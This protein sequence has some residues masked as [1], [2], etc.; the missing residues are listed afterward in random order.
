MKKI[1]LGALVAAAVAGVVWY[2]YD[3]ENFK[4][5]IDDLKDKADGAFGKVKDKFAR[6]REEM[7]DSL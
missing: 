4:D 1:L 7:A 3:E 6:Q 5:T 2:L